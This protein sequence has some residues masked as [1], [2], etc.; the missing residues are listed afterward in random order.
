MTVNLLKP[1]FYRDGR[2]VEARLLKKVRADLTAHLGGYP[3]LAQQ[4]LIERAARLSLRLFELDRQLNEGEDLTATDH[5]HYAN[6]EANLT[7]VISA[8]GIKKSHKP[9]PIRRTADP[10]RNTA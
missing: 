6:A 1:P 10:L 3:N 2:S 8:L 9:I 7:K 4:L 5:Q